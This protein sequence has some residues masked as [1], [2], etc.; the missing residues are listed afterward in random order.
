M[1]RPRIKFHPIYPEGRVDE[2]YIS[3]RQME[4]VRLLAE[5]HTAGETAMAMKITRYTVETYRKDLIRRL[6][7][8]N[9]AHLITFFF[10]NGIL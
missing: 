3:E 9:T 1:D 8:K 6:K 7:L 4:M 2:E 10:K 5:G